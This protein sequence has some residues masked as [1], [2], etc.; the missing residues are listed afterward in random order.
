MKP[1]QRRPHRPFD[2]GPA[3]GDKRARHQPINYWQQQELRELREQQELLRE[4][5]ELQQ[6]RQKLPPC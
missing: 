2:R 4:Q 6:E 1:P 5:Q 3:R